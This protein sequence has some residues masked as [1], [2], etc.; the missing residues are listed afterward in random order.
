MYWVI[1]FLTVLIIV[2]MS[3]FLF[4]TF[5]AYFWGGPFVPSDRK[6]IKKAF[7]EIQ[8][9]PQMVVYD[10]GA[11]DGRVLVEAAKFGA[12]A[13][14]YELNPFWQAIA[15]M[16][17]WVNGVRSKVKLIQQDFMQADFGRADVI[18]AYLFPDK[19]ASLESILQKKLRKGTKVI[20]YRFPFPNWKAS[21][22][23]ESEKVF[24]YQKT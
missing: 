24:I 12:Q 5:G 1:I 22:V 4:F 7:Q 2:L 23:L 20:T 6:V 14:G 8:L 9:C 16:R 19:I 11:G 15:W 13:Y 18:Y 17:A 21:K 10:L 3:M